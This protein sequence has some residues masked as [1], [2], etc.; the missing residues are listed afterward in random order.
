MVVILHHIRSVYNVGSIFRTADAL[1]V[2]KIYLTGITPSPLDRF[3]NVRKDFKKVSLGAEKTMS[4]EKI[5][6]INALIQHLKKE[7]YQIVAVEQSKKSVPYFKLK[8]KNEKLKVALILGNEVKGLPKNILAYTD[9]VLEIPMRGKKESLNV[10]I[11]FAIVGYHLV[12]CQ[13]K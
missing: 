6:N 8:V 7:K 13:K 4:W 2:E 9:T 3:G 5:K 12:F 1:G 11:A 10:A